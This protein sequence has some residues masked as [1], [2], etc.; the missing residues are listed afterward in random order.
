MSNLTIFSEYAAAFEETLK[1]DN[2]QRLEKYFSEAS[3]YAP[4]DGTIGKG[5]A[6]TI[7]ALKGSVESLERK[8][9]SRG[10]V[11]QPEIEESGDTITLK[12]SLM[13]TKAGMPD[14]NLVGVETIRYK[15]GVI[16]QM[17]DVFEDAAAMIAWREQV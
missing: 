1:D 14:L 8:V 11:G 2:W 7:G 10:L 15:D 12:F 17:E 16:V 5:L 6:G 13:Y 3:S 9:D 4:G